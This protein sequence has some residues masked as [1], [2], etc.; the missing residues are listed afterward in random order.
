[1]GDLRVDINILKYL[2]KYPLR[3]KKLN[4]HYIDLNLRDKQNYLG[5]YQM[6]GIIKE[7]G[8]F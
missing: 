8:L 5:C 6:F 7:K 2:L 4:V 3:G 1:M